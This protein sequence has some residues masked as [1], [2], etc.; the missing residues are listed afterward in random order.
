MPQAITKWLLTCSLI[1]LLQPCFHEAHVTRVLL[2]A[3][4]DKYVSVE[5]TLCTEVF[6][7][8]LTNYGYFLLY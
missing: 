5:V 2:V 8:C 1:L 3:T 4:P 6:L 7:F